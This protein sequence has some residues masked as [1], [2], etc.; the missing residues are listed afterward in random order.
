MSIRPSEARAAAAIAPVAAALLLAGCGLAP[1]G[2]ST[3]LSAMPPLPPALTAPAPPTAPTGSL[4]AASSG[5]RLMLAEDRRARNVGDI[6]TVQLIERVQAEKS[7]SQNGKRSSSRSLQLPDSGLTSWIP[8]GLFS[9]GS[10]SSF[11]GSGSTKQANR[12]QGEMTVIVT[13]V[14]PNGVLGISGDREIALTRGKELLRL[15]GLVRPEDISADNRVASTRI[16]NARLQY[17]GTGEVA[18]QVRQGWLSRFF[19]T[20]SPF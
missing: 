18:N 7:A 1:G 13:N 6:L 9:G 4:W 20:I 17:S 10:D 3:Q 15:T 12:L 11:A 19:D 5:R 2:G 8:E 16:A 14:L